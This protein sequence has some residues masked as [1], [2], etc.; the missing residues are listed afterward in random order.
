M[1]VSKK[2][3]RYCRFTSFA[4]LLTLHAFAGPPQTASDT[5]NV[6]F[7]VQ[8]KELVTS[9]VAT[10]QGDF[11]KNVP[12]F[13]RRN[14]LTGLL[15][16]LTVMQS[17]G[18]PGDE[19]GSLFI[20]G[21]RTLN[22]NNTPWVLVDGIQ[23]GI[24][25]LE[26]DE[27]ESVTVLK[28][29]AALAIYGLRG[30]NGVILITTKRGSN[31][32]KLRI[33]LDARVGLQAPV[34]LPKYL[35]SYDYA[36]LYNEALINDG[37]TPFYSK[38]TLDAYRSGT[39][40]YKYPDNNYLDQ[41][42][43]DF[44]VQQKYNLSATGGNSVAR[45]YFLVGYS[46]N[47][48]IYNVDKDA[49]TYKTN[50][51]MKQYSIRSNVD[52]K[53][54]KDFDLRLDLAG[55]IQNRTYPG[56]RANSVSDIFGALCQLP[57]NAFPER[58]IGEYSIENSDQKVTN[59]LAGTTQYTNNPYGLL[60]NSGYSAYSAMVFNSTIA[61]TYRLGFLT[62]GLSVSASLSLDGNYNK[63]INRSKTFEVYELIDAG[64]S[65]VR[66]IGTPGKMGSVWTPIASQNRTDFQF[67]F[68]Y[69][70]SFGK[71]YVDGMIR[72]NYNK[73][74]TNG[75]NLP[76]VNLGI[77]GRALYAFDNRYIAEF[78]FAYTGTEQF[79]KDNRYGFFPAVSLGWNIANET[80]VKENISWMDVLKIRGSYGL[81]GSDKGIPYF[82]YIENY[83]QRASISLGT[84]GAAAAN[85]AWYR[86]MIAN[87]DITWEKCKKGNIGLD[88]GLFGNSLNFTADIFKE[89]SYDMLVTSGSTPEIFGNIIPMLNKG[90]VDNKG[91]ELSVGYNNVAGGLAYFASFNIAA[92]KSRIKYMDEQY[93]RDEYRYATGYS[94]GT[95]M[96][97]IAERLFQSPDDINNSP[98]QAYYGTIRPGDIK[99]VD[100]NNDNKIDADDIGRVGNGE[101]PKISYG[102]TFGVNYKGFDIT[103]LLQGTQ[104]SEAFVT[105][106]LAWEFPNNGNVLENHLGRWANY[107]D[108][109]SGEV[110]NTRA[111]ATYPRLTLSEGANN[112]QNSTYW[113]KDLSYLRL[114]TLEIGYS[115]D[116]M[117]KNTFISKARIYLSGYNLF[118]ISSLDEAD[119]E[120]AT[121]GFAYPIQRVVNIGINMNF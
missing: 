31:G 27:I 107:T 43:K 78:S 37:K 88:A 1:K 112:H 7:G 75:T 39:D 20:R 73:Y 30:S 24:D 25:M 113:L 18:E 84:G 23:R 62:E 48:G 33:N 15:P 46:N 92:T 4:W 6:L 63:N 42:L 55:R 85:D 115:F 120:M 70:R 21:Q 117:L 81:T 47:S 93:W 26:P 100:R 3:R 54:N 110:V 74:Q 64:N 67:G 34:K 119:P 106:F 65:V 71:N 38:E 51:D 76:N 57:P 56:L 32:Q 19:G 22:G 82:D 102:L 49:N 10:L 86:A 121:S 36:T 35:G 8:K 94:V 61:G 28:D 13:N 111:T 89:Q 90:I 41:Y 105:G 68:N 11:V 50:A 95:Q 5:V 52:V 17:N 45:Y 66:Q 58:Y 80:F 2:M 96:G 101:M 116:K 91:F 77:L 99:Y 53:V 72:Y 60:N 83:G 118:T 29:A 12:N 104:Q 69:G 44:S 97:L 109:Y 16:G 59:P 14:A 108:P 98:T 114:K 40:P 87:P 103:A 9:S 79:P